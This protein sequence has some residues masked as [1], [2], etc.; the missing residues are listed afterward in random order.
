MEY[1]EFDNGEE[2]ADDINKYV[3]EAT[4]GLISDIAEPSSFNALTKMIIIN[5]IYFK[6]TWNTKFEKSDTRPMQFKVTSEKTIEHPH[7]MN[8]VSQMGVAKIQGQKGADM[9]ILELPYTNKNFV[10]YLIQPQNKET[11]LNEL[12]IKDLD[13][14]N[15]PKSIIIKEVV[16]T[17][18]RFKLE[19]E[20]NL[21]NVFN[22][23]G[24]IDIFSEGLGKYLKIKNSM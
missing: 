2:A 10:M 19:F 23:L 11:Q 1:L 14:V 17:M 16:L 21:Q 12:D 20:T 13:F 6:G 8:L 24:V 3:S 5:A 7:G 9:T 22:Q 4:K 18:P 15:L